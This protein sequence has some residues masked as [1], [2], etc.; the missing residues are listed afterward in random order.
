MLTMHEYM[1]EFGVSVAVNV[2]ELDTEYH[3]L[4]KI[5]Y[6]ETGCPGSRLPTEDIF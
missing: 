4:K 2:I 1:P 3:G 5:D 6:G